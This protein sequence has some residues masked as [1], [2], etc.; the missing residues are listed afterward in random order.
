MVLYR[1][2]DEKLD[3]LKAGKLSLLEN[4]KEFLKRIDANKDINAFNFVFEKDALESAEIIQEK[5]KSGKFGKLAGMVIAIKDVLSIQNKPLTCSSKILENFHSVYTATAVQK[6]INEDAVIIG[7]TSCDEF[8]MGSSNENSAFGPV[9]N[10]IDK[11]RVPGG[12]SGGSAAALAANL[13]DASIGT[14]TGGSIRQ[15][16]AF[17]GLIGLKPTYGRVSRFGLTAY[18]SSFDSIGPFAKNSSD[19]PKIMDVLS[20][21]DLNDSTSISSS[22]IIDEDISK[23]KIGV[24]KEFFA[25]GLDTEIK[26]R[27]DQIISILEK[28]FEI[29]EIEL[30]NT[31]Y[32]IA[33]Y[34][35][36]TTAEASSNLS[37]YDGVRYGHRSKS[38]INL[39]DLYESS[40]S[41]GFGDE[42]KRRIMLGTYVLS[43]GYYDAYYRKAQKVRRIIKNDFEKAFDKVDLILSPTTPTTA[44][45]IG[46][47]TDDPLSM[48]L[49]DIYT[50]PANLVGIPAISIPIGNDSNNLPIGLQFMANIFEESK[51][52]AVSKFIENNLVKK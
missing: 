33:A 47:K 7:K 22:S 50:T 26:S 39:Q 11:T 27:I 35:I 25:A 3:L 44:F 49:N 34:Y 45:K 21:Q 52:I 31:K 10:P 20:G 6:L 14:D 9:K 8:A 2:H 29:V 42:V 30:P 43:A 4:V 46:E 48:Y 41:E 5:I 23:I 13:C 16:A 37:R 18:A 51:L 15:P 12:S 17:T 1:D 24:P 38:N 19:L 32:S 40:R 36:L 28:N